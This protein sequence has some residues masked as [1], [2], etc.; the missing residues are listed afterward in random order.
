M[1]SQNLY[2]K[3]NT[4]FMFNNVSLKIMAFMR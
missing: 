1:Y 4:R 2:S 3:S